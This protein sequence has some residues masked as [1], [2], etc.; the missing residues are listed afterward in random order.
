MISNEI[1]R[2]VSLS[3][4][5]TGLPFSERLLSFSSLLAFSFSYLP[6]NGSLLV[7]FCF[8]SQLK[9]QKR[10]R[11]MD[12]FY[13]QTPANEKDTMSHQVITCKFCC[14]SRLCCQ[15]PLHKVTCVA[16]IQPP[17]RR[18]WVC[19]ALDSQAAHFLSKCNALNSVCAHT[20][21]LVWWC[22]GLVLETIKEALQV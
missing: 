15:W 22:L 16:V 4:E 7:S 9:Y 12:R 20:R 18:M 3:G 1:K 17:E 2:W 10:K 6:S 14:C 11:E 19:F 21:A 8:F 13:N 5:T